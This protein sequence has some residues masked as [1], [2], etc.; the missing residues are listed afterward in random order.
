[1]G[2]DTNTAPTLTAH[3]NPC[4]ASS[5]V[6]GGADRCTLAMHFSGDHVGTLHA[7]SPIEDEGDVWEEYQPFVGTMPRACLATSD[8]LVAPPSAR[9]VS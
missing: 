5:P 1:M 9:I 6:D 8:V 4:Y 7:W 2:M 3:V